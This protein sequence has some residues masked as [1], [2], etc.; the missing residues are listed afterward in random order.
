[1]KYTRSTTH[2]AAV[3]QFSSNVRPHVRAHAVI[4][5]SVQWAQTITGRDYAVV[6]DYA[7]NIALGKPAYSDSQYY[8]PLA[9][10]DGN[11]S[12]IAAFEKW[13]SV[14]LGAVYDISRIVLWSSEPDHCCARYMIDTEIRV[15]FEA[16]T[17]RR[18]AQW[19]SS[20]PSQLV[21]S[22]D[23]Q[24]REDYGSIRQRGGAIEDILLEQP[25]QGRWIVLQSRKFAPY[26]TS[27]L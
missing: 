9:V 14:D 12:T 26:S 13:I 20:H 22:E 17:S 23:Q 15:G 3:L 5:N 1:M 21:W 27:H 8:S 4:I 7:E 2:I 24:S 6:C 16:R 25:V 10:V 19:Q 18:E 11:L